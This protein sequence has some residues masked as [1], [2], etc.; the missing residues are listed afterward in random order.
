MERHILAHQGLDAPSKCVKLLYGQVQTFILGDADQGRT[1]KFYQEA[2]CEG[3]VMNSVKG[4]M[5]E[6]CDCG[7]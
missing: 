5:C 3:T 4:N 6:G 1:V 2:D 7:E